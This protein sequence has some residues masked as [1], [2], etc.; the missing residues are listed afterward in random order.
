MQKSH[1]PWLFSRRIRT[2]VIGCSFIV[3]FGLA[4]AALCGPLLFIHSI[5]RPTKTSP[6]LQVHMG[7]NSS[8]RTNYWTP[9]LVTLTNTGPTFEGT[10]SV[11]TYSGSS[12]A[13]LIDM[14]SPWNFTQVVSLPQNSNKRLTLNV[15]HAM[16]FSIA[17]G[18]LASLLDR[19]GHVVA[20]QVSEDGSEIKSGD[21]FVGILAD[22]NA[23]F[24]PLEAISLPNQTTMP[25]RTLLNANTFPSQE[26]LLENFDVLL[27]DDFPTA[28]LNNR[29]IDA[30]RSW[31]NRGGLLIEVGGINW[32][33]TLEPLPPDLLPMAINGLGLLPDRTH[34][35]PLTGPPMLNTSTAPDT[36]PDSVIAS[37][38]TIKTQS[39]FSMTET[40]LTAQTTAQTT[41]LIVQSHQGSGSIYYLAFDPALP[42]LDTWPHTKDLWQILFTHG[43][44]NALIISNTAE[45]YPTGPGEILRNGGLLRLI[46]PETSFLPWTLGLL[47]LAYILILGPGR[48]FLQR[49]WK[50]PTWS[51]W[52][53]LISGI[54]LFTLLSYGL[55]FYQK[56]ASITANS[57]SL[58]ELDQNGTSAH[59]T[60]YHGL[61]LPDQGDFTIQ[62][63]GV[64]LSQPLSAPFFTKNP[65][66]TYKDDTP[67]TI[68][69]TRNQ[70][71]LQLH[72]SGA[73]SLHPLISEQDRQFSG[74][75]STHLS[76]VNNR[77]KGTISNTLGTALNDL[78]LLFPHTFV[79]LGDL[80]SNETRTVDLP[81]HSALPDSGE[82]IADQ[83]AH[84]NHVTPSYPTDV[85]HP[86][87][88]SQ[89][90]RHSTLL[91]AL[92]GGG[93][94]YPACN[95]SCLTHSIPRRGSLY[96][97][98]GQVPNPKLRMDYDP[99]LI[100][101]APA[102]LIGW[103]DQA[104]GGSL[105]V[106][107]N[108]SYPMGTQ[109]NFLRMPV[110][111]QLSGLLQT[112]LNFFTGH[113]VNIQSYD[114]AMI[115]PG[116]YT[117]SMGSMT[118]E[119]PLPN[120][121]QTYINHITVT[122]P[123]LIVNPSGVPSDQSTR[124]SAIRT[125]FYNWQTNT[126]EDIHLSQS[127]FTTDNL[128]AYAGSQGRILLQLSSRST[129]Q[130]FFSKPSLTLSGVSDR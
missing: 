4:L 73:W 118:F 13:S 68:V 74:S 7:F 123:D 77:L 16:G 9:I 31:V 15:P 26:S 43:L 67:T 48:I 121:T 32:R 44:G 28:T 14:V 10:L 95:G 60:S 62:V 81:L 18:F 106:S 51:T 64:N 71:T 83:I 50:L 66:I 113:I 120:L 56:E 30:L 59:I 20:S 52:R 72:S 49:R 129:T 87:T 6:T 35:L 116:I 92:S 61:Y 39:T 5:P 85:L 103:A 24:S 90:Q 111:L 69:T 33:Q 109:T 58:F 96:I 94:N 54:V 47:L 70:T 1:S 22:A 40:L 23:D 82:T 88:Q 3:A 37:T 76:L 100:V 27:L 12:E 119:L 65:A 53:I 105:A 127:V 107:V 84:Q 78:Y 122:V 17:R 117:M 89:L 86:Q 34:L 19:Q 41:P 130:I 75:L 104:P 128:A 57:I 125:Q 97:T 79:A 101:G 25:A 8:Y 45:N 46:Q 98:G 91:S 36:T 38:A 11:K 112:P 80:Q 108:G 29:Q 93:Y 21:L 124:T 42:P 126:W 99:L 114:A 2:L 55:A 115:L 102:T 110:N 63:P